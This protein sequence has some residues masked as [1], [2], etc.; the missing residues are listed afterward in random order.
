[1]RLHV[2]P[3]PL[4][5]CKIYY[6]WTWPIR[7]Y[8][9]L[10]GLSVLQGKHSSSLPLFLHEGE[11]PYS[12]HVTPWRYLSSSALMFSSSHLTQLNQDIYVYH[13]LLSYVLVDNVPVRV[14][15]VRYDRL[16]VCVWTLCSLALLV[17]QLA[18][19]VDK[20]MVDNVVTWQ[21]RTKIAE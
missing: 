4:V 8:I 6:Q 20:A 11:P 16:Y 15:V 1:M 10:E 18:L 13:A 19:P 3:K 9:S 12:R 14:C 17:G 7:F 21:N 5:S 2:N